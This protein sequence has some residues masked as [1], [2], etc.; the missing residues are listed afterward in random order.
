MGG[1]FLL[2]TRPAEDRT[3]ERVRLQ[4]AF[5]EL[6]FA[7]PEIVET[8]E[9]VLAA[10][11]SFQSRLPALTRYPNGDFVFTCGTCLSDRGVGAP[12]AAALHGCRA[13]AVAAGD[14]VMGHYAA[15]LRRDGRTI[16]KLDR[17]CGYQLFY[18]LDAGIVSSSFYAICSALKSLTLSQ[19][20]TCEYVFNGV[21]SGNETLFR[22]VALAAIDATIRVGP[23]GLEIVR[24][25]LDAP[26]TFTSETRDASLDRSMA[27]LD[28][29]FGSVARNFGDR[30]GC[31]LSG[32]YDSRLIL[33]FLRRHGAKPRAFVYGSPREKDVQLAAEI[34]RQE[35]FPLEVIDKGAGPIIPPEM[36]V[37]TARRNF[38]AVDGYGYGGI[39]QNNAEIGESARRV[40]GNAIAF[41]GGGGEIFRN[42]FYLPD[43]EY[44]IR[45]LL[46]SFYSRF[47]P[48]WCTSVFDSTSYSRGLEKKVTDLLGSDERRLPRPTVEWLYHTFRCRAWDGK[49]DSI[50]G[51][52]GYTAMPYLER[53]ITEHASTLRLPWKNHGAY[54]AELIRRADPRLAGYRSIYGH[55][56]GGPPPLSRRIGDYM[57]YL[58]PPW[59][60]RYTYRLR[61]FLPRLAD[62]PDYL[63]APYRDVALPEGVTILSRLFRLRRI[64]DAAQ[65]ARILS[66]EY[67]LRQFENRVR[68]EF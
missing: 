68:I 25:T 59:L 22:E 39:F 6:G 54:E 61:Y 21:V 33:A 14:E 4:Q 56:F 57:T 46:W 62:W 53:P 60:R 67:A 17:F 51:R 66:L 48:A 64:A 63:A 15:V 38:L 47:D 30:V 13:A 7:D 19:Q 40:R 11:P 37:E 3:Q 52:Y 10:Y 24:P 26:R 36:F 20:S 34:A 12:A 27:L 42:F 2:L 5:A 55:D 32:G 50:A 18:N 1:F 29:Y 8:K 28:R 49:V 16:I 58:R 41:N 23:R 44:S 65:F 43:R 45:E 31:A 9:Y 35:G